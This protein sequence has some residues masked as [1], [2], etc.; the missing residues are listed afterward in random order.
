MSNA[1][2]SV[3]LTLSFAAKMGNLS[4]IGSRVFFYDSAGCL[5]RGVVQSTS[6]M[7]DGTLMIVI[8]RDSGQTVTLPAAGV[9]NALYNALQRLPMRVARSQT[10]R[11]YLISWK[12]VFGQKRII[13]SMEHAPLSIWLD[14]ILLRNAE[15]STSLDSEDTAQLDLKNPLK[16]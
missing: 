12:F 6:R 11:Y 8:K 2:I 4:H 16:R 7:T 9:S 10:K 5:T 14:G 3:N 15:D 1:G 13:F